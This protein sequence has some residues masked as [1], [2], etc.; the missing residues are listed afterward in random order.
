MKCADWARRAY[1]CTGRTGSRNK[2]TVKPLSD[3]KLEKG[4]SDEPDTAIRSFLLHPGLAFHTD[5]GTL[6]KILW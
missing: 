4:Y 6:Y 3:Y 5:A 2:Q 1:D